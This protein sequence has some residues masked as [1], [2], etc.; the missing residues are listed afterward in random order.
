MEDEGTTLP[1]LWA[2]NAGEPFTKADLSSV[3]NLQRLIP[4]ET[5]TYRFVLCPK[6]LPIV[7][8]QSA[9]CR[10]QIDDTTVALLEEALPGSGLWAQW[11]TDWSQEIH[12]AV[13]AASTGRR[14][15]LGKKMPTLKTSTLRMNMPRLWTLASARRSMSAGRLKNTRCS[16]NRWRQGQ[17][18]I[19]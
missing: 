10:G 13:L 2:P 16:C 15:Q 18:K 19:L 3:P 12:D 17:L 11:M 6:S 8:G 7:M 4:D 14:N 1:E 9:S 5:A